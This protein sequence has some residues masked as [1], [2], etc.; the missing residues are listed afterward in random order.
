[1]Y[2]IFEIDV[3]GPHTRMQEG[4]KQL[5]NKLT[6]LRKTSARD[7]QWNYVEGFFVITY[8]IDLP[9]RVINGIPPQ[10]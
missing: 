6:E 8:W 3:Y 9:V 5:L 2:H 1:M 4:K 7:I 10:L